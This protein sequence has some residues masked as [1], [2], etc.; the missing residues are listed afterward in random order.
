MS[1]GSPV[2]SNS[3]AVIFSCEAKDNY[4]PV[5]LRH[6]RR[7]VLSRGK[8]VRGFLRRTVLLSLPRLER[9]RFSDR[10]KR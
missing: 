9:D 5:A 3:F 2:L 10:P 7:R 4:V 8:A 6:A 1:E